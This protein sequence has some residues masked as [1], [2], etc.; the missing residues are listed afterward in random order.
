MRKPILDALRDISRKFRTIPSTEQIIDFVSTLRFLDIKDR[1]RVAAAHSRAVLN[2]HV[3]EYESY[4][5]ELYKELHLSYRY[6]R[7]SQII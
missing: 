7:A 2:E 1:M 6:L 3:I 5:V 4:K